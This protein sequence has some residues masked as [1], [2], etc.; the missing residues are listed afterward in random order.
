MKSATVGLLTVDEMKS[1]QEEAVKEREKLLARKNREELQILKQEEKAKEEKRRKQ[2][3]QIKALSFNP[4]DDEEEEE[5]EEDQKEENNRV[6]ESKVVKDEEG[7]MK[8]EPSTNVSL[9]YSKLNYLVG[10]TLGTWLALWCIE[11]SGLGRNE[12]DS[13]RFRWTRNPGEQQ[14]AFS[15]AKTIGEKSRCRHEFFAGCGSWRGRESIARTTPTGSSW[16][17][18]SCIILL[19]RLCP[20]FEASY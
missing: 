16:M 8:T 19:I 5:D 12:N 9:R 13:C 18:S 1:R 2:Q 17:H 14:W 20:I 3:Q 4:D 10:E 7:E 11:R 6:K 15:E